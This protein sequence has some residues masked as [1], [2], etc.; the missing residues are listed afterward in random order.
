MNLSGLTMML[1]VLSGAISSTILASG[2]FLLSLA[3]IGI[4]IAALLYAERKERHF[5]ERL[6]DKPAY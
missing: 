1:L 4:T 6:R 3:P 2:H 5:Q